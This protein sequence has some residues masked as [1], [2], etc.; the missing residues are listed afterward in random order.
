MTRI[1]L[2][3]RVLLRDHKLIFLVLI[4]TAI[5]LLATTW[6]VSSESP[7]ASIMIE[8]GAGIA[9]FALLFF[10]EHKVLAKR[11][12]ASD[13]RHAESIHA[14]SERVDAIQHSADTLSL[15]L[16]ELRKSTQT[17]LEA[18]RRLFVSKLDDLSSNVGFDDIA[19]VLH[20]SR[21][22]NETSDRG[23]RVDLEH[24]GA[25]LRFWANG[26]SRADLEAQIQGANN[27]E[28]ISIVIESLA[29]ERLGCVI[30][31]AK[32][33]PDEVFAKVAIE[34]QRQGLYLGDQQF[35]PSL[36]LR[37][38]AYTLRVA[39]EIRSQGRVVGVA[40]GPVIEIVWPYDQLDEI[41][42]GTQ[43]DSGHYYA[44]MSRPQ[45]IISDD[46]IES[47]HYTYV[48][49]SFRVHD[50]GWSLHMSS[51]NWVDIDQ[52]DIAIGIARELFS[53]RDVN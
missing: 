12:E 39:Y 22:R 52:F 8:L 47:I 34:L 18:D 23:P 6:L 25:R 37:K 53:E 7:M 2:L 42:D 26:D 13:A 38:L 32:L 33:R 31:N 19:Y 41:L 43:F 44:G 9:L 45:W 20:R 51:K 27:P 48:I 40:T 24:Y 17:R 10:V 30:W 49:E 4:I 3:F 14:V 1:S 16:D 5:A 46:G 36:I 21:I 28:S 11:I 35:D 29:G 15:T 50:T